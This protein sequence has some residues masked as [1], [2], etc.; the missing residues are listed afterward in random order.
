MAL[1]NQSIGILFNAASLAAGASPFRNR[2]QQ[3]NS[4]H[5]AF[6]VLVIDA[7]M[8]ETHSAGSEVTEH[9]VEVG[10]DITDH[11]RPKPIE[12]RIDGI[13]TNAPLQTDLLSAAL[14]A[15]PLAPGLALA[16]AAALALIGKAEFT[17][18]AYNTLR[19]I[20]DNAVLVVLNTA[21]EAYE[22]MVMSDLQIVRDQHTGDA[23]HFTA[24]FR[25]I[26][27]VDAAQ[28]VNLPT[29][30]QDASDIGSQSTSTASSALKKDNSTNLNRW[31]GSGFDAAGLPLDPNRPQAILKLPF[32]N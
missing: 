21:Y 6:D 16:N 22:N 3:L 13:V 9:P 31:F 14:G 18:D 24:T 27:I 12:V 19:R 29:I 23:L 11:V 5:Q 20:R 25:Q 26:V 8:Q 17:K 32:R 7:T 10:S 30:A 2:I 28:L 4:R 1:L 15:S